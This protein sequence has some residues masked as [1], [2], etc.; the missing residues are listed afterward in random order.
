MKMKTVSAVAA[1]FL[2]C[3]LAFGGSRVDFTL[4]LQA[5][6]Q[7]IVEGVTEFL[8]VSSTGHMII[9]D[10]FF[11]MEDASFATL[12]EVV[13]QLGAIL[14]VL[15]YFYKTIFP[16]KWDID[17]F[18]AMV[19]LWSRVVVGVIPAAVIGFLLDDFI[20]AHLF[21]IVVVSV[22]LV[23]YGVALVF[24]GVLEKRKSVTP[25][26][27][28]MSYLMALAVGFFQ[29]LAM[30]PGTSR[31]A[32]TIL[33]AMCLGCSRACAAEF[34]FFLAIPTMFGASLLKLVKG[35]AHLNGPQWIALGIGFMTAFFVA[36]G[37]IAWFMDYVK[38]HDFKLFGW[39]RIVLGAVL[40]ALFF[41]GLVKV[42]PGGNDASSP[43]S[44]TEIRT[45]VPAV[46]TEV[47]A[48]VQALRTEV[49]AEAQAGTPAGL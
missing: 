5:F 4:Y 41:C 12:F 47:Q 17:G 18:K 6:I 9:V 27:V 46:Q 15:V 7:G 29:C 8:P 2:C 43:E 30:V 26:I 28:K 31:S 35:G 38:K 10:S 44:Q 36:W 48:E 39:Y 1:A 33:G 49:Q 34:S 16:A 21:N 3:I 19:P 24:S 40:L 25:A 11:P 22:A 23:V 20:E 42:N 14:S 13:I 45:E 32:V 37:V